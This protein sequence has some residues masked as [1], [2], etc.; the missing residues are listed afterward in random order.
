MIYENNNLKMCKYKCMRLEE[1]I[2]NNCGNWYKYTTR[3]NI[4]IQECKKFLR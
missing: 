4:K 1:I 3:M 2:L